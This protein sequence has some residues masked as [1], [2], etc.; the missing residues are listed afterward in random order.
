[1]VDELNF[2]P[3]VVDID[4]DRFMQVAELRDIVERLLGCRLGRLEL[5]GLVVRFTVG[6]IRRIV[7]QIRDRN[8]LL[9]F[10]PILIF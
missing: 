9:D 5:L 3:L 7:L 2:H 4:F 8:I 1:M 10:L 6:D